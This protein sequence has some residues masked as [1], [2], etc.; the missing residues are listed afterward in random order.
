MLLSC[1]APVVAEKLNLVFLSGLRACSKAKGGALKDNCP[2]RRKM[3]RVCGAGQRPNEI[4]GAILVIGIVGVPAYWH[5]H[6]LVVQKAR[7]ATAKKNEQSWCGQSS[8]LA[9][10]L[11]SRWNSLVSVTESRSESLSS[12]RARLYFF[13]DAG[14]KSSVTT[15][16][17]TLLFV[18]DAPA[19]ARDPLAH[20]GG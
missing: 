16:W 18:A 12:R 19:S 4:H 5:D 8:S 11:K 3:R 17:L 20:R 13:S 15:F 6:T 2:A 1:A 10:R 7:N 9:W 14:K